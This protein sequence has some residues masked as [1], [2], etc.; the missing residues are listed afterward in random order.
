MFRAARRP[1]ATLLLLL[2]FEP[3]L[4]GCIGTQHVPFQATQGL[5]RVTGVT[6]RAGRDIAFAE[7]GAVVTN[8]TLYAVGR[9][10]QVILPT[11]SIANTWNRKTMVGRSVGLAVGVALVAALIVGVSAMKSWSLMSNP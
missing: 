2:A 7:P 9:H 6:T 4:T 10:G 11:D 8:D 3:S 5:D 1:I